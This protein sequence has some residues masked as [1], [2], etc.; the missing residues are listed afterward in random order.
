VF[1]V[2]RLRTLVDCKFTGNIVSKRQNLTGSKTSHVGQVFFAFYTFSAEL[3]APDTR[4]KHRPPRIDG[5]HLMRLEHD[6]RVR[7][8]VGK[9][10]LYV[11]RPIVAHRVNDP[12][13]LHISLPAQDALQSRCDKRGPGVDHVHRESRKHRPRE[14]VISPRTLLRK[15]GKVAN[16]E[17]LIVEHPRP[18]IQ[19]VAQSA[20]T[21]DS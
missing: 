1:N 8:I 12:K 14:P 10:S 9:R 16:H 18:V 19:D 4:I 5:E 13:P 3:M 21:R 15:E 20:G 7:A 2:S 11:E 17:R 6:G